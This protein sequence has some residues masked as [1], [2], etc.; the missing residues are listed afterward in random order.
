LQSF[1]GAMIG[2]ILK[3]KIAFKV[4]ARNSRKQVQRYS[5]GRLFSHEFL[6][7]IDHSCIIMFYGYDGTTGCQFDSNVGSSYTCGDF[8][9]IVFPDECLAVCQVRFA[10]TQLNVTSQYTKYLSI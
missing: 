6:S 3:Q 2:T 10:L 7:S 5:R 4:K 8:D 1:P 9:G